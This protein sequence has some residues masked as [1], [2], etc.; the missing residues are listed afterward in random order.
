[1]PAQPSWE[2]PSSPTLLSHSWDQHQAA[3]GNEAARLDSV[4]IDSADFSATGSVAPVPG[5]H[6]GA[7]ITRSRNQ[8]AD[9][10]PRHVIDLQAHVRVRRNRVADR[11]LARE[12][13]RDT[14]IERELRDGARS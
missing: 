11:G 9:E 12:R 7:G 4:E 13:I 6:V 5:D 3:R 14:R 8:H 10:A 1:M 2:D